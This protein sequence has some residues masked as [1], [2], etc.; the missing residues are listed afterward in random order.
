M[1]HCILKHD[2]SSA[3]HHCFFSHKY[4]SESA[5]MNTIRQILFYRTAT[6]TQQR[7]IESHSFYVMSRDSLPRTTEASSSPQHSRLMSSNKEV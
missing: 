1:N 7:Y 6:L 5:L 2:I 4:I 3:K